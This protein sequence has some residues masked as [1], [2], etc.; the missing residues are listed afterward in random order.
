LHA[1]AANTRISRTYPRSSGHAVIV[2]VQWVV[3]LAAH[4]TQAERIG[5]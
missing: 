4:W 5:I 1:D 3:Y 2:G